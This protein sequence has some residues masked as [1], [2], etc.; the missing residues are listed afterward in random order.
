M[1][2]TSVKKA[3]KKMQKQWVEPLTFIFQAYHTESPPKGSAL[4]RD[5]PTIPRI[6]SCF[7]QIV[8]YF[9]MRGIGKTYIDAEII[10]RIAGYRIPR[11]M[12]T[13]M[14]VSLVPRNEEYSLLIDYCRVY[15]FML[16]LKLSAKPHRDLDNIRK[17]VLTYTQAAMS[18]SFFSQESKIFFM[19]VFKISENTSSSS[20]RKCMHNCLE[21]LLQCPII[22]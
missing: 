14:F 19:S 3:F 2:G 5:D 15:H 12:L 11:Q 9:L 21:P 16:D 7:P 20:N 1:R 18:S 8:C 10:E 22:G 4:A 6:A 13:N 17:D